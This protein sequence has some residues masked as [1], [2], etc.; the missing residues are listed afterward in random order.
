MNAKR[1]VLAY[2]GGLDTSAI[3]VWLREQA[4]EVHAVLVD[5]GQD[6]DLYGL[7]DKALKFGAASAVVRDARPA[8][9]KSVIPVTIA[10]SATYE[11]NYRLGTALARPFIALEQVKRA[12]ELGGATLIHGATGKGNDQI[13]FEFAYRSLAPDYPVLAPWKTWS[14]AGR[15]DLVEYLQSKGCDDDFEVVKTYSLDENLWHLSI[16]GGPLEDAAAL[17]DVPAI[18]EAVSDRFAGKVES[19]DAL[20][21]LSIAFRQGVPVAID[22]VRLPLPELIAN[23]NRDYRH[24]PW[25]W[26]LVIENRFTGIK[27]RGIY[28]NP[29]AKVLQLAV[30]ALARCCLNKPTYDDYSDLGRKY[31]GILYRGEYFSDQRLSAEASAKAMA[32]RL[33]G[34]VTIQLQPVPYVSKIDVAD[35]IFQAELATFEAGAYDHADAKGFIELSWLSSI[36]RPF[37]EQENANPLEAADDTPPDL[38]KTQSLPQRGLVSPAA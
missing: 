31:G 38:R 7:C 12:R 25:A 34:E 35:S 20:P 6:E 17:V 2:S 28:L 37:Q 23:L 11:G 1:C 36:G 5:V 13:R 21:V 19:V 14:F 16:E 29:A 26:D 33:T 32:H 15:Q 10:L 30:D 8:M 18:L 4:Y 27:S 9:F 22:G 3:V 24:A